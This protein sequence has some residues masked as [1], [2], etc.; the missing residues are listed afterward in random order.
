MNVSVR[1]YERSFGEIPAPRAQLSPVRWSWKLPG[2]PDAAEMQVTGPDAYDALSWLRRPVEILADGAVWWGYIHE[3]EIKIEKLSISAALDSLYNR[4]AVAYSYVPPGSQDVG[5]RR[6]TDWASDVDS[7][8]LYGTRELLASVDGAT[9][10]RAEAVRDAIL[11]QNAW[12]TAT[13]GS[14]GQGVTLRCLGWWSTL[15]WRYYANSSTTSTETTAQI[16]AIVNA[17]EFITYADVLDTT[18]VFS[19]AYRRGDATALDEI[20][21]LLRTRTPDGRQLHA[22]VEPD[23]RLKIYAESGSDPRADI[24]LRPDGRFFTP[25]G[26][27][28]AGEAL[29]GWCRLEGELPPALRISGVRHPSPFFVLESEYS[30][31]GGY[32]WRARGAPSPWHILR[33]LEG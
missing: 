5:E 33:T 20:E 1:M 11:Q 8:A 27:E 23:R 13:I 16:A 32:S 14:G 3:V 15:A 4:V 26:V 29:L 22:T 7:I 25:T 9:P 6:T 31:G 30:A 17:A 24:V 12:P 18:N 2:G 28:L 10:E 19:S 21:E